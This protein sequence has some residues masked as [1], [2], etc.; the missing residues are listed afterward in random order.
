M[1][2]VLK[3]AMKD[4]LNAVCLGRRLNLFQFPSLN[5]RGNIAQ[6]ALIEAV[7]TKFLCAQRKVEKMGKDMFLTLIMF[8][9]FLLQ[10]NKNMNAA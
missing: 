2:V 9:P 1:E 7:L 6:R 3:T 8:F 5:P 4:F 10:K